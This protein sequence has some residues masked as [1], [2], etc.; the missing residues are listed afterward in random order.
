[1]LAPSA[2]IKNCPSAPMFHRR[3]RKATE[4][5]RPTRMSGVALT[6]V[7]E[8]TPALPNEARAI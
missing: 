8:M 1:M 5:A 7:S 2:P 6:R 4:Q 3:I